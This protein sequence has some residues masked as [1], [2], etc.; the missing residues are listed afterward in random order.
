[1]Q[2]LIIK[3]PLKKLND[4]VLNLTKQNKDLAN[5]IEDNK[6]ILQNIQNDIKE[7]ELSNFSLKNEFD[8]VSMN[9]ENALKDK[10]E[11]ASRKSIKDFCKYKEKL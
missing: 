1:M 9:L 8:K 6:K 2:L 4:E 7:Y 11:I 5:Q 10:E 3:V